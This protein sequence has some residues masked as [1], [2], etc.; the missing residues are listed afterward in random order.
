[1]TGCTIVMN[2]PA[3]DLVMRGGVMRNILIHDW[4]CYL[5]VSAFGHVMYDE[6]S[7]IKYR[8]HGN[9]QV[10]AQMS[11]PGRIRS[12]Y[13]RTFKG[14]NGRFPSEQNDLFLKLYGPDLADDKRRFAEMTLAAKGSLRKR[15]TLASSHEIR[16]QTG[17]E[18]F[19]TRIGI[20]LN[21]F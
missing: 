13:K 16:M 9:N 7:A 3:R 5:A 6:R 15:I 21:R 14:L 8:Q 12:R 1:V 20:L 10:S 11:L 2:R 4:W 17:I 19:L 18:N